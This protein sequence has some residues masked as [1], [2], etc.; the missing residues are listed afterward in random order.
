MEA[1]KPRRHSSVAARAAV[2]D[3]DSW[4]WVERT[5]AELA[6]EGI[7]VAGADSDVGSSLAD[8]RPVPVIADK[9]ERLER[10]EHLVELGNCLEPDPKPVAGSLDSAATSAALELL[11]KRLR[12]VESALADSETSLEIADSIDCC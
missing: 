11:L 7:L 10:K 3:T 12:L 4:D 2:V 6:W 1:H 8:T 5:V 9:L